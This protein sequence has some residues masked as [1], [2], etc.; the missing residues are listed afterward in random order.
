M[1]ELQYRK[2]NVCAP[3][4]SIISFCVKDTHSCLQVM[5]MERSYKMHITN[6]V[7]AKNNGIF[8]VEYLNKNMN[9]IANNEPFFMTFS[10]QRQYLS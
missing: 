6:R 5:C 1:C 7:Q 4:K 10:I 3:V 9:V 2:T 8:L